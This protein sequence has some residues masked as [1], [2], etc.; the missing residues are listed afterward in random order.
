MAEFEVVPHDHSKIASA[1]HF[2]RLSKKSGEELARL[3]KE[4]PKEQNKPYQELA[5]VGLKLL[6]WARRKFFFFQAYRETAII[7]ATT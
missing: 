5:Q 6:D 3:L 4:H 1:Y 7:F 2:S